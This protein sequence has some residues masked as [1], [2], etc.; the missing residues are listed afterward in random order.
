MNKKKR[1]QRSAETSNQRFWRLLRRR[2]YQ[3]NGR[4]LRSINFEYH[5]SINILKLDI[6]TE[7][8]EDETIFKASELDV[9]KI[10]SEFQEIVAIALDGKMISE[11]RF[12][13]FSHHGIK[14]PKSFFTDYVK[15]L[16][17]P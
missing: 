14:M 13:I 7:P 5:K 15:E 9:K 2:E 1:E 17:K 8:E 12:E 3:R 10:L 4:N 6:V 11:E 16:S